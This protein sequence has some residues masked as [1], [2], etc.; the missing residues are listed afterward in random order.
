MRNS[1]RVDKAKFT[2]S[3][4]TN[5]ITQLIISGGISLADIESSN[6]A[7]NGLNI[8]LGGQT[9]TIPAEAFKAKGEKFSCSKV[10]LASGETA[11]A[12]LDFN[13]CT[14]TVTLKGMKIEGT[15][16]INFNMEFGEFS[17]ETWLKTP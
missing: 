10:L 4:Q 11:Y 6:P 1:L 9:F 8:S 15:G 12:S 5:Q 13:K 3:R 2:R 16:A 14:F 17:E 7:E